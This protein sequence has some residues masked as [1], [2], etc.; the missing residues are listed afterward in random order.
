MILTVNV[1]S[2]PVSPTKATAIPT[3]NK[4]EV[5][6]VFLVEPMHFLTSLTRYCYL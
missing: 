4:F 2:H 6:D 5:L 3:L 1:E